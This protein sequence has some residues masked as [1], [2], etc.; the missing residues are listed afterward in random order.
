MSERIF[1]FVLSLDKGRLLSTVERASYQPYF[2]PRTLDL[3][4]IIEGRT[5]FWLS[6][7]MCAVVLGT[8]IYFRNGAYQAN[9]SKGIEL[10][11]HE[12]THI[13]QYLSGMTVFKYLWA[14]RHGYRQNPYEVEAYAKGAYVC[15][16][17]SLNK[18][19]LSHINKNYPAQ[20]LR[21]PA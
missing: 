12:L 7:K 11:A 8:D 17:C 4:R 13:E 21:I 20:S 3:V 1:N 18:P 2:Q 10:L 19:M 14:S 6:K 9:T 16:Q 5:P 15:E